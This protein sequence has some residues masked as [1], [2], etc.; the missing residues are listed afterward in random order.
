MISN[1]DDFPIHQTGQPVRFVQT[2][3]RNFY[4][5]YYFNLHASSDELFMVMG[6]GQYPNLAVQ[7]AF[8]CVQRGESYRVVRASRELGDR[9]DTSVGPFRIE[10]VKPLEEVRFIL[11]ENEHGIAAELLWRGAIPAVE[12]QNQ[13]IRRHGRVLFDTSRFAQTGC[14]EGTLQV[15]DES[16]EVT[17]DRWWGTRDRSWG[18]RPHGEP[19][20][21][22]I[23]ANGPG[24]LSGMWNYFPMQVDDH[25][26]LYILNEE[27]DGTVALY[28]AR[29][30]WKDPTKPIENLGRV[31][32]EHKLTPGTRMMSGSVLKFPDA[33]SGPIEIRCEPLCHAFIAIGT[34]YTPL[35]PEWR[36]GMYQG[37][38]V[39]QGKQYVTTEIA[40]L[41]Q[42]TIVDHVG[43]YSYPDGIGYGLYEHAFIGP[44]EKYGMKDRADGAS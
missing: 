9:M 34:G 16:F 41:G 7:D 42:L 21:E 33:P 14:W 15:G 1:W 32:Y 36:H 23:H 43:R 22:G 8:A 3:D 19:E 17:P 30:I 24:S 37:P 10:V 12:E 31:E 28:D 38:L 25:S 20:P 26:I 29:R 5:R 13:F 27:D 44:F 4:D 2:S 11:E 6:L 39:V 40:P 35:E 18:I